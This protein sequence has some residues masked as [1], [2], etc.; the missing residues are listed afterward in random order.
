M[1]TETRTLE[2]IMRMFDK[3]AADRAAREVEEDKRNA[4]RRAEEEKRRAEEEKRR[5]EEEK[6]RAE[7]EK[8]R[9]EDEK[10][11][12]EEDKRNAEFHAR[13]DKAERKM[14]AL[15]ERYGGLSKNIGKVVEHFFQKALLHEMVFGGICYNDMSKNLKRE[16][17]DDQ[18]GEFD[19]VLHNGKFT[20]L[21]EVKHVFTLYHLHDFIDRI[22]PNFH[23]L[24][25]DHTDG[26]TLHLGIASW[27]FEDGVIE[28]AKK[29]GIGVL[30]R[31][32][33]KSIIIDDENLR[34]Y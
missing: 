33:K 13:W 27:A 3:F 31:S 11:R 19:I 15:D 25:H 26:K 4:E 28:E 10:R 29:R 5:A 30:Q 23:E 16:R 8:R 34:A 20:G 12:A 14:K 2:D 17:S 24:C 7:E 9:A 32:G 1:S 22:V 6:R 21:I 18:Q